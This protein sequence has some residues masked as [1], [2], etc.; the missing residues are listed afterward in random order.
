MLMNILTRETLTSTTKMILKVK[1]PDYLGQSQWDFRHGKRAIA[2]KITDAVWLN[3]FQSRLVDVRPGDS[4][5]V[6]M[7]TEVKYGHNNEVVGTSYNISHV[8]EVLPGTTEDQLSLLS[9]K[10]IED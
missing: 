4:L 1:R 6:D 7:T 10:E 9:D 3:K 5:R 2:A 8:E